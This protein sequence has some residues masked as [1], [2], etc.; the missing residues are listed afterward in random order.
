M[1]LFGWL[2]TCLFIV[3][4]GPQIYTTK[5]RKSIGGVS[6][7]MWFIQW[8]AYTS[9]L[10]YSIIIQ[11]PPLMFGYAMGWLITAWWL[12]LARQYKLPK[13]NI[14]KHPDYTI[15]KRHHRKRKMSQTKR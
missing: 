10:I 2:G 11:A 15:T 8:A 12:E 14:L 3:C 1:E 13:I 5:K 9:C 6:V 4:Y 7:M